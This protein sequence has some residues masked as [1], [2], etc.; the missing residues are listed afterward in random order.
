[1]NRTKLG[2]L[3]IVCLTAI[4]S[5]AYSQMGGGGMMG[6]RSGMGQG[7]GGQ[8]YG[9]GYGSG[10]EQNQASPNLTAEEQKARDKAFV[11]DYIRR[12]L[13][14]YTLQKKDNKKGK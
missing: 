11:E 14:E 7:R 3:M 10:Q 4:T 2:T 12:H 9:P 1:M 6:P 13:P 8:G 5:N